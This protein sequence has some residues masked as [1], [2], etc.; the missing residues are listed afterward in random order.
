MIIVALALCSRSNATASLSFSSDTFCVLERIIVPAASTWLMKNSP[1]FLM[2]I[3]HFE[4]STTTTAAFKVTSVI[5]SLDSRS[6][7]ALITSESLPTPEGSMRILSGEYV[8]ITSFNEAPKS[9]TNEQQIH[10]EFISLISIPASLR[11]PPSIPISPNSFS[12]R[13]TFSL[14]RTSL[15]IFWINVVFPAP[16]NPET[17]SI[18]VILNPFFLFHYENK[19]PNTDYST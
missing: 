14:L 9:P 13:T 12:M 15:S 5:F 6:A 16:R 8:L 7:T 11:N 18:L 2:Y 3:L 10:P 1:K 19:Y 4:T 17:M